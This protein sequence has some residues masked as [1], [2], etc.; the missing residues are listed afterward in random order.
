LLSTISRGRRRGGRYLYETIKKEYEAGDDYADTDHCLRTFPANGLAG[1]RK[2]TKREKRSAALKSSG[3]IIWELFKSVIKIGIVLSIYAEDES[4]FG[5]IVL[6]LLLYIYSTVALAVS[7]EVL[8]F[9]SQMIKADLQ[10]ID[11]RQLLGKKPTF[12]E[13]EEANKPTKEWRKY[14]A[15]I[16]IYQAT[17]GIITLI[18]LWKLIRAI[19]WI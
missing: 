10:F 5:I 13:M 12:A 3:L 2:R 17:L 7:Q 9:A 4:R 19:G 1:I 15:A 14:N 16:L 6:S 8:R 11:I 18:A